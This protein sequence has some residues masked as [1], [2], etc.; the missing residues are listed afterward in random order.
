MTVMTQCIP[1]AGAVF[2]G[3]G[4]GAG[5]GWEGGGCH[6]LAGAKEYINT[7]TKQ[8]KTWLEVFLL[9]WSWLL[10]K[11]SIFL[12]TDR[13]VLEFFCWIPTLE[14]GIDLG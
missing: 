2:L 12:C 11:K 14:G 3:A 7:Q 8:K 6:F 1:G 13:I 9:F 5:A 10:R 4:A